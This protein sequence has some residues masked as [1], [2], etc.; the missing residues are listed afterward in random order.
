MGLFRRNKVW[1]MST[2]FHGRQIRRSTGTGDRQLAEAI[3][4]KLRVNIVEGR[5]FDVSEEKDRTFNDMMDRYVEEKSATKA[6]GSVLRDAQCLAHL[7]PVFGS[8]RLMDITPKLIA[9]YKGQR[10]RVAKPATV[11]KELG[12]IRHAYN[13]AMREWEWCRDNPMRRVSLERVRNARDRWLTLDE[14]ARLLGHATTP[15]LR[16]ILVFALN[17]GMRRGEIL[18]LEWR[19]VDLIRQVL[20]VMKS[21]NGE[22]RTLPLNRLVV[23]VLTRKARMVRSG[24]TL[25]FTT[26]QDTKIDDRNLT[27]AFYTARA[28]AQLADFRFHDLRHTFATRLVQAGVDLYKVQRLLGHKSPSMTQRYAHHSPESLRE[29]VAILEQIR[30]TPLAQIY[31]N[32]V[33]GQAQRCVSVGAGKGI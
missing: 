29:G 22:K 28:H 10:R 23:E 17:T 19:A 1:W 4:G 31:H 8:Y 32:E 26:S 2:V 11:N 12:L 25:V 7:R 27:R 5:F 16:D 33:V 13:V 24:Q 20:V 14:E 9:S 3:F 21:K 30:A 6:P 18:G 15:W